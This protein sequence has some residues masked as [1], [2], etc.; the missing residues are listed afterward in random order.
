MPARG[1]ISSR[2]LD[3]DALTRATAPI[4]LTKGFA[5]APV[6]DGVESALEE[7]STGSSPTES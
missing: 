3:A 6:R 1:P 4:T 7:R 5:P 2:M